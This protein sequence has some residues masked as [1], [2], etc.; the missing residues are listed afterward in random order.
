M[1]LRNIDVGASPRATGWTRLSGDVCYGDRPSG[2]ECYWIEVPDAAAS[3]LSTTGDAWVAWLAPLAATLG[4][5]LHIRLPCDAMLLSNIR[6]LAR[7]WAAWYPELTTL[8]LDAEIAPSGNQATG[9]RTGSFFSGGVDSFFTA[10]THVNDGSASQTPDIDDHLVVWGFDIPLENEQAFGRVL[11]S[12]TQAADAMGRRLVPVVTNLR[13][14]RFGEADWSL[15]SHGAALAGVAHALAGTYR[16][17]LIPSSAGYHDLAPKG[18]HPLTDPMLS[19]ST[20]RIVH[21]GPAFQRVAKTEYLV[22]HPLA[23]RHLR[24]CYK[25]PTGGNC[26]RCNKCYR[27]MLTLEALGALET[28]GTFERR[29]LDLR[30]AGHVYCPNN[31][32]LREFRTILDLARRAGRDDIVR[33]VTRTLSRS[34]R[35]QRWVERARGFRNAPLVWRWALAWENRL[36]RGWIR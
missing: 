17:V 21:D 27:T 18:S 13:S 12:L 2:S 4:E 30:R 26:G 34:P 20:V 22:R 7:V 3:A 35:R 24:V 5:T 1:E 19:S 16:T 36:L 8:D 15:L 23:L 31:Y 25:D 28:T 9:A 10:L 33:A 11:T 14:T 29:W 32:E 6:E